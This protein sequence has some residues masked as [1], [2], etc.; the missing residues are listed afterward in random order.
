M[1]RFGVTHEEHGRRPEGDRRMRRNESSV[2][3]PPGNVTQEPTGD[4]ADNS[5]A[6]AFRAISTEL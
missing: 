6:V 1:V 2:S 5:S 3:G 4:R